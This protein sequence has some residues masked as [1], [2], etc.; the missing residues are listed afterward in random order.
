MPTRATLFSILLLIVGLAAACGPTTVAPTAAPAAPPALA[1]QGKVGQELHLSLD[2]VK[3]LGLQTIT[4]EHPKSG[5]QEYEGVPLNTVLDQAGPAGDATA[6][7][8]NA[9]DGFSSEVALADVRACADC[10]IA[11]EG[12]TLNMVMPGMSSKTWVKMVVSIEV[13]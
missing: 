10:L 1:V 6:V 3:A 7:V 9:S 12:S 4:A 8:F 11:V 13:K 2:D 5:P